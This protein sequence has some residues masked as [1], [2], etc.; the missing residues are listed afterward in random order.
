MAQASQAA[1]GLVPSYVH[2]LGV[3]VDGFDVTLVVQA[4]HGSPADRDQD[5]VD[6]AE[7]LRAFLGPDAHVATEV[8]ASETRR[9]DTHD[10]VR[11]FF[12]TR[13]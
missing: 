11:W 9:L 12:A 2:A 3:R 6:I 5:V 7:D 13:A 4:P 1:L 10:G 8:Q